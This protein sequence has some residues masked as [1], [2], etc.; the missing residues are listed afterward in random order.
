M[1][2]HQLWCEG[3]REDGPT[4][5]QLIEEYVPDLEPCKVVVNMTWA[6]RWRKEWQ[7]RHNRVNKSGIYYDYDSTVME[8]C[9]WHFQN[10]YM[11]KYGLRRELTITFDESWTKGW[12]GHRKSW[13]KDQALVGTRSA[14]KTPMKLTTALRNI[15]GRGKKRKCEVEPHV[16]EDLAKRRRPCA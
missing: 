2:E 15:A 7:W 6:V 16:L 14:Q 3:R 4:H 10:C 9:R 8:R 13:F 5:E 12:R 1:R 11:H